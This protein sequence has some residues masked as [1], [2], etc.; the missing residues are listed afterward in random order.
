MMLCSR[1]RAFGLD[2]WMV[3]SPATLTLSFYLCAF[4]CTPWSIFPLFRRNTSCSLL[5]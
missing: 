1:E 4:V 3:Q 5:W 2:E